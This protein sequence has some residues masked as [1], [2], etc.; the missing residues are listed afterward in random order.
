MEHNTEFMKTELDLFS[1]H[2]M[3]TN[4]LKTEEIAYN[5]IASLDN[6]SS[7]EFMAV[8][9]GDTYRDLSSVYLRLVVK[10]ESKQIKDE[11]G[12]LV[13]SSPGVVNNLLH[14]LFRNCTI[15]LN[16]KSISQSDNNYHYRS[17]FEK[18][19]NY[20]KDAASTHL[21]TTGW[22]LDTGDMDSL[23][24]VEVKKRVKMYKNGAKVEL[25]G[26]IHA[27]MFNQSRLLLNNVD[28]KVVLNLE[29][30]D[31]YMMTKSTDESTIKILTATMY[32]NHVTIN[33]NILIAHHNILQKRNALY[34]YKRVEVKSFTLYS[35]NHSL[36]LDNVVMGQLPNLLIFAMVTSK[37]Y[38]GSRD[39]NPFNFHHF[40]LQRF[41]LSVNG[42]QIPSQALEFDFLNK[43]AV[44]ST[45][46]YNTLFNG[47]GIHYYDK[48]H[49]ITKELYDNGHF[50][51]AFDLTADRSY[52]S[53]CAN[54]QN[55]G[56]I[57]IEGRFSQQLSEPITCLIYCE[58]DSCIKID[59]NRGVT[60]Q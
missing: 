10:I 50:M 12:Q 6:P 11:K 16:N 34:P 26:K 41:S 33:P 52:N 44:M 60:Q 29:K 19:L 18:I 48:G 57:R 13:E 25:M 43:N 22:N 30:S 37:S 28:L 47:T 8:G 17:Y 3:Q 59:H 5:P 36:F 1:S 38:N 42:M 15:Y 53:L 55:Q 56:N 40:N 4:I 20:G 27:D 24:G 46:G 9:N 2:P 51:L 23:E 49:Q 7:I 58:Y 54:Y 45:R 31:F 35:G 39:K 14:S 32:M 21:E